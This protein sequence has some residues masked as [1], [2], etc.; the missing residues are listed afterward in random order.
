MPILMLILVLYYVI[1]NSSRMHKNRLLTTVSAIN[2][3]SL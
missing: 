1:L 2:K 3:K